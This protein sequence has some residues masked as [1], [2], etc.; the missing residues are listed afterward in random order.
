MTLALA[1]TCTTAGKFLLLVAITLDMLMT[2]RGSMSVS[3]QIGQ[4]FKSRSCNPQ[5]HQPPPPPPP[6]Q[7]LPRPPLQQPPPAK[8]QQ[9]CYLLG[10]LQNC[11]VS[12]LHVCTWAC[13]SRLGVYTCVSL[14]A[15]LQT[16]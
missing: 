15:S 12:D 1:S 4:P 5:I 14:H 16:T 3:K 7:L 10:I 6:P 8:A 9:H 11:R 13:V 2:W